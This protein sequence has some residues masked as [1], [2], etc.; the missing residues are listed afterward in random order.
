MGKQDGS[1][2]G[3]VR[4]ALSNKIQ[5]IEC[6]LQQGVYPKSLNSLDIDYLNKVS[7]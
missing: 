3:A 2:K 5:F 1:G 4:H 6:F 7:F